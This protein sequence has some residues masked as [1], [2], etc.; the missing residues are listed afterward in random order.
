M[1]ITTA[2]RQDFEIVIGV[3]GAIGTDLDSVLSQL[4]DDLRV[5]GYDSDTVRIST[6][7]E[8]KPGKNS[9]KT[10]QARMDTC[11]EFRTKT[12]SGD[13]MAALAIGKISTLRG[14]DRER[15]KAWLL[16]SIKHDEEVRLLRAVFG[17]RFILVGVRQSLAKRQDRL[18]QEAIDASVP[19]K[20]IGAAVQRL[21]ERDELDET[22]K[23]G[24]RVRKAFYMADYFVDADG[25]LPREIARLVSLLFGQPFVTP[26]RDESAMYL[27]YAASLRSADPGRQVGAVIMSADGD[28]LAVGANEVPKAGGGEYWPEDDSDARDFRNKFDFNKRQTRRLMSE[29]F[30]TLAEAGLLVVPAPADPGEELIDTVLLAAPKLED[31]RLM[32]LIEFGRIVHAEMSALMQ[33]ARNSVGVAGGTLVTTTFPCHMCMRLIVASGIRRVVFVDPYPKSLATEMYSDSIT[34]DPMLKNKV[35][36]DPYCGVGWGIFTQVFESVHRDRKVTGEFLDYPKQTARFRLAE[37]D[38]L[39]AAGD[40]EYLTSLRLK[41][42]T[43]AV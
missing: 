5:Y 22:T 16:R 9:F 23:Y 35:L 2:L 7:L 33:V 14:D 18:N 4:G 38:P 15:R 3:V 6:L 1:L 20:N 8:K 13:A 36:I 12:S 41:E 28:V 27:A 11:D 39:L 34:D 17:A 26:T 29:A 19:K 10:Y 25:D 30:E 32:S 37:A 40:L 42:R 21:I 43:V 24:Q 31:T